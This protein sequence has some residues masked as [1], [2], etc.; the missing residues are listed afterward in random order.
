MIAICLLVL[1]SCNKDTPATTTTPTAFNGWSFKGN[2]YYT[3]ISKFSGDTLK[4]VNDT[5][6]AYSTLSFIFPA[7]PTANGTYRVINHNSIP[8]A[9][10]VTISY[11]TLGFPSTFNSI[12]N[13]SVNATV[14][15]ASGKVTIT[16]PN[17]NLLSSTTAIDTS[18]LSATVTQSQ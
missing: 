12:G 2:T 9:N 1:P 6:D 18:V 16:V 10:Q 5:L 4:A 14:T 7:V 15:V 11:S 3:F 17:V 13:D 8:A